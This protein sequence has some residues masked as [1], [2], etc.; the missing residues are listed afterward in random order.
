MQLE[1]HSR[2]LTQDWKHVLLPRFKTVPNTVTAP[3]KK[4]QVRY[5]A[6]I[7][8]QEKKYFIFANQPSKSFFKNLFIGTDLEKALLTVSKEKWLPKGLQDEN[9][10]RGRIKRPPVPYIPLVDPIQDAVE[11]KTSTKKFKVTLTNGTIMYHNMYNNGSN[12]AFVIHVQ[13]VLNFCKNKGFFKSFEKGK[14]HLVACTT[15][16]EMA[17][18]KLDNAKLDPT[19]SEDRMKAL[20]R[21]L[22]LATT[23]MVL[24]TQAIPKREKQISLSTRLS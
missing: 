5:N 16:W 17:K 8:K 7:S 21:S 22:E 13:E 1:S 3:E 6:I 18:V 24:A 15:R 12:K 4:G 2:I 9:V 10:E 14:L 20:K 11:S 19:T 23:A